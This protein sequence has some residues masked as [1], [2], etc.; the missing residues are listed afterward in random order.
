MAAFYRFKLGDF[1]CVCLSDGGMNYPVPALFKDVPI[2]RAEA[3]LRKQQL[4]TTYV[5]T[6]Y[7]LLY[8]DTG[9]HKVLVDTGVGNLGKHIQAMW[10]QIDHSGVEP[11]ILLRSLQEAG[12]RPT[13]IDTVIITH[14]HPDHIGG[15]LN[16][17]KGL[18]MPN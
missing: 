8:I 14:A 6:P 15:N 3:I 13:D 12:I 2:D 4:P 5:Y 18:N 1:T 7:T 9:T 11:G 16:D 10:P 17:D